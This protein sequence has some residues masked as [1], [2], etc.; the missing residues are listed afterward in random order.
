MVI[1]TDLN[2]SYLF[3]F[4]IQ[5]HIKQHI[6]LLLINCHCTIYG[7]LHCFWLYVNLGLSCKKVKEM[8]FLRV[9]FIFYIFRNMYS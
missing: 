8:F 7:S 9:Q 6:S 5:L 4:T 1:Y 3:V 2:P